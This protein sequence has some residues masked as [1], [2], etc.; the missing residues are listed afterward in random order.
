MVYKKPEL[1]L[2]FQNYYNQN[3]IE[4]EEINIFGVRYEVNQ[5]LDLWN[6]LLGIWTVHNVYCW[7]GTTDPGKHATETSKKGAAH[8]CSGYHKN[9]W[10]VGIHAQNNP[11]F[12]H[13]ALRQLGNKV[14]IW[15]DINHNY[16][17]DEKIYEYDYL[18]IN[19]HRASKYNNLLEI[20]PYS[21]GCQVTRN[22]DDFKF[23]MNLIL[24]SKKYKENEKCKFSYMLFEHEELGI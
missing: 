10:M 4:I 22:I 2:K 17:N 13:Q 1:L 7:T 8:L 3:N 11:K 20:G 5:H 23:G 12:A 9:I 16:E 21:E 14:K 18:G 15:R 24:N 6:D 19:W